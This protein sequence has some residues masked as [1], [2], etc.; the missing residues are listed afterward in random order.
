MNKKQLKL[1][2]YELSELINGI[3]EDGM[4]YGINK[5]SLFLIRCE[6]ENLLDDESCSIK[7]LIDIIPSSPVKNQVYLNHGNFLFEEITEQYGFNNET[8]SNGLAYSDLDNDGDLDIII[9]NV[10]MPS[11]LYK[12][13][14]KQ[15]K[16]LQIVL[17]VKKKTKMQ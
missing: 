15:N 11:Y 17:K 13:N 3:E 9:N 6:E 14:S 7:K 10:N 12:N 2:S 8:F 1:F 4:K 16:S 5:L